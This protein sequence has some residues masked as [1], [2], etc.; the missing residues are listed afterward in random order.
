MHKNLHTSINH[1]VLNPIFNQWNHSNQ[2]Q[3]IF[4]YLD[5]CLTVSKRKDFLL[6]QLVQT[7]SFKSSFWLFSI[8]CFSPSRSDTTPLLN[9]STQDR[10]FDTMSVEIEQLLAKVSK[11]SWASGPWKAGKKTVIR[12][13]LDLCQDSCLSSRKEQTAGSTSPCSLRWTLE[14]LNVV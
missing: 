10:M 9:N 5:M 7:N 6:Q 13:A 3:C 8:L 12:T 4:K 11:F 2:Y 14:C 1:V